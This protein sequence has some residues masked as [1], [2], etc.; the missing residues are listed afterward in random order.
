MRLCTTLIYTDKLAEVRAFYQ[1]Y[2]SQFP[3]DSRDPN[4]LTLYVFADAGINWIDAGYAGQPIT[5]GVSLRISVPFTEI[6]QAALV[7]KG[8]SC[9]ALAIADWGPVFSGKVQHFS[10]V[11]PSGTQLVFYEDQIG[12]KKQ[13]MIIGDG[14]GTK[15]LQRPHKGLEEVPS[16]Q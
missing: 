9:S 2:F 14:T 7:E 8:A 13:I 16:E 1:R 3:S 15:A 5:S 4:A 11:D 6:E 12:E 10:V